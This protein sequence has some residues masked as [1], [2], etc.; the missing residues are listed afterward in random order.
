MRDLEFPG[1]YPF[2][3]P[4][5]NYMTRIRRTSRVTIIAGALFLALAPAQHAVAQSR[6]CE[7]LDRP[8]VAL[9]L[10]GGG[11]RGGVHVGVIK[12]L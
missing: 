8:C 5:A 7:G 2:P 6:A 1:P 9:V 11:A 3:I 12:V 10:A 4:T